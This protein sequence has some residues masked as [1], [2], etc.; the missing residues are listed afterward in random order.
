[1]QSFQ[2]TALA[3]HHNFV[4]SMYLNF[5]LT[6][7][8]SYCTIVIVPLLYSLGGFSYNPDTVHLNQDFEHRHEIILTTYH[9][10][11]HFLSPFSRRQYLARK[12]TT[13]EN[14][15]LE[16]IVSNLGTLV[17][18]DTIHSELN[19]EKSPTYSQLL[20]YDLFLSDKTLLGTLANI[21]MKKAEKIIIPHLRRILDIK[22]NPYAV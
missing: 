22:K 1:M 13:L 3:A 12:K 21:S 19:F 14:N 20:A 8:P 2:T 16:E 5:G 15:L 18:L 9:E 10:S 7:H 11:G 17:Y 4:D 6:D